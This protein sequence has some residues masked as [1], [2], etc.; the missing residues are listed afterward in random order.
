M[1]PAGQDEA[2]Q[3]ADRRPDD[4]GADESGDFH[5][6][7]LRV[8]GGRVRSAYPENAVPDVRVAT[9]DRSVRAYVRI[10]GA[11]ECQPWTTETDQQ[12][13]FPGDR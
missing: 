1:L 4:Q 10:A 8:R 11:G 7:L 6:R 13:V 3:Q 5:G 2:P 9:I 12:A